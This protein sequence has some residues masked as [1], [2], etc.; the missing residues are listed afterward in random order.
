MTTTREEL[1]E[2]T[3]A[4]APGI[5]ARAQETEA[6]RAPMDETIKELIDAELMQVLVPKRF[7]GHELD[8][9]THAEI[10]E[11]LG[12]ACLSTAW[13][14]AFYMG[15]N[16]MATRLSEK[17]QA[18]IFADR[19]F[20]LIPATT[21]PTFRAT[22]VAGGF[23]VTG[24][25][26][27]GSGIMHADWV[28]VGGIVE[29]EGGFLFNVPIEDVEV[30]DV[31][32]MSGMSGTGSNDLSLDNVFVPEHRTVEHREFSSG[33]SAG[34]ALHAHNPLYS[35]PLLPFIYCE[36]IGLF[37]GG[38]RGATATFEET[39]RG[40]VR[41]HS[42]AAVRDSQHSH[43]Q[44]GEAEAKALVAERLMR[45]QIRLTEELMGGAG[46]EMADRIRLKA[47]AGHLIDHCRRAVNDIMSEAGTTSF[48]TD[49][50]IQRH[51]RDLNMLATHAFWDWPACREQ[52]GRSRL[53]LEPTHP[54][55]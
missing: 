37:S 52:L 32:H 54:L 13:I 41:T 5:A 33:Q 3:R 25:A 48:K 43:V 50:P 35:L 29:G 6:L 16:W 18:E 19:P 42:G 21:A 39:V 23:E 17:A 38:L 11:I 44:L 2:R 22:Q 31:W 26:S 45:D 1:I 40:R 10:V 30:H 8:L 53:G 7:G 27:W 46:F 34:A 47:H 36:V 15:H 4:I 20:G 51:F 28:M 55:I 9:T 12:E 24:Q 49:S 14:A